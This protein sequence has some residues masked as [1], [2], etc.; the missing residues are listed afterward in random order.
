MEQTMMIR[1][2]ISHFLGFVLCIVM[3]TGAF[4]PPAAAQNLWQQ[5]KD[6]AQ[7]AKQQTKQGVQPQPAAPAQQPGSK[8]PSSVGGVAAM[9]GGLGSFRA[10]SGTGIEPALM[11]PAQQGS[12]FV[13]SDKGIHVASKQLSGSRQIIVYDGV[14]GPKFDRLLQDVNRPGS[15]PVVFSPDGSHWAYCGIQGSEWVVM[16]DGKEFV[17][18]PAVD[19]N[20]ADF[21]SCDL[22]FSPNS[23]HLFFLSARA[24]DDVSGIGRFFWDGKPG[25]VGA[26]QDQRFVAISP[27]GD[28]FAYIWNDPS[29]HATRSQLYIDN[30]PASYNAGAPQW[31]ADSKHL[32]TIR[33]S[34][35]IPH[36]HGYQEVLLDGKVVLRADSVNV[37]P[38]P[39]GDLVVDRITRVA[40][41]LKRSYLL[42]VNGKIVVGSETSAQIGDPVFSANGKHYAVVYRESTGRGSVFSDGKRGQTYAQIGGQGELSTKVAFTADSSKL[43]Y[44]A[45]SLGSGTG[46]GAFVVIDDRESDPLLPLSSTIIAPAGNRVATTGAGQVTLDGKLLQLPGVDP[47]GMSAVSLSFS[48]DGS[49]YAFILFNRGDTTLYLDGVA[50]SSYRTLSSALGSYVWSPDGKHVAYFC[51]SANPASGNETYLCY[52]DK[53]VLLSGVPVYLD[54]LTF[55]AD[56]NHLYWVF[57]QAAYKMRIFADGKPVY[58][59]D[60]TSPA[61]FAPK[62]F[63]SAPDGSLLV[64]TQDDKGLERVSITPSSSSSIATLFG[65]SRS[66]A[67][68]H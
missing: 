51:R 10:P 45:T 47:R 1:K 46:T 61:G 11:A 26:P 9:D 21:R 25:P 49:H 24:P 30:Q 62:T 56:S 59:A 5:L 44:T 50:Q 27:D 3:N 60:S 17:R 67:S 57:K 31:S 40:P 15:H 19:S 55:S 20:K 42:A 38:A 6:Q 63:Q 18:Q 16:L 23:K 28:H 48:P 65:G 68:I 4:S 54:T 52:D 43:V 37:F 58:D 66:V 29:P 2:G 14:A 53:A 41:D 33:E 13:V 32:F 39:V 64:L 34:P 8:P 36:G 22:S 35:P 12:V 7:K